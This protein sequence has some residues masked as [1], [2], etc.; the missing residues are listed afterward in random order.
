MRA[1]FLEIRRRACKRR[2]IPDHTSLHHLR[3][4][5]VV[6]RRLNIQ[7]FRDLGYL[8]RFALLTHGAGLTALVFAGVLMIVGSFWVRKIVNSIAL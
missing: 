3:F 8:N 4:G 2:R 5:Y 6:I 7:A 1:R